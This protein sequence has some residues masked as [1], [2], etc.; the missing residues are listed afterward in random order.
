MPAG[1]E[2]THGALALAT[3]AWLA[4][5]ASTA[6]TPVVT[7]PGAFDTEI[8]LATWGLESVDDIGFVEL[9][10]SEQAGAP[11]LIVQRVD[12]EP[13]PRPDVATARRQPEWSDDAFVIARFAARD[14]NRLG[15]F[16]GA[17][18]RA[19]S[20]ARAAWSPE[21]GL[22][23]GYRREEEGWA[24]I[25]V[26]MFDDHVHPS[27]RRYLDVREA[28]HVVFEVRQPPDEVVSVRVADRALELKEEAVPVGPLRAFLGETKTEAWRSVRIPVS[29]LPSGVDRSR[30]ASLVLLVDAPGAGQ[31]SIRN[32][33][34][35]RR[36]GRL[37]PAAPGAAARPT[38]RA[39]SGPEANLATSR[40]ALWVWVAEE[41]AGSQAETAA[42]LELCERWALTHVYLQVPRE[43]LQSTTP[44]RLTV[45][46][47]LLRALHA[48]GIRA[49]ALEG[50]PALVLEAHHE[51]VLGTVRAV[52]D[53]NASVDP[54]AQFAGVRFDNEPYLLPGF[55]GP[56]QGDI[57]RQYVRLLERI[58]PVARDAGLELGVDIPFWFD[59]V[60]RRYHPVTALED[61][62][63][64]DVILDRVDHVTLMDYRTVADGPDGVITH[65]KG[66]LRYADAIGKRVSIGLETVALPNERILEFARE[67]RGD[68]LVVLPGAVPGRA[69]LVWFGPGTGEALGR[70]VLANPDVRVLALSHES[71]APADKITFHGRSADALRAVMRRAEEELRRHPSFD[72]FALHSYRSLRRMAK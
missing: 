27:D 30:L 71:L 52:A 53:Y 37:P 18:R 32:L 46:K 4:G 60:D 58:G 44:E 31:L 48:R 67:G 55:F 61:R 34:L 69:R 45:L 35:V 26:H 59:G 54:S 5:C 19:P 28:S 70:F 49:D 66:E 9:T 33:G 38:R 13:P 20:E 12:G 36:G 50:H 29:A 6:P 21:G 17:F 22:T 7:P 11:R 2:T 57:L 40:R 51:T 8:E 42:L 41:V 64:S 72:G 63:F 62:P 56:R 16:F 23:L 1:S 3:L 47:P 68:R 14:D 24:G 43:L 39:P 15:G 25:W 65:A 10:V